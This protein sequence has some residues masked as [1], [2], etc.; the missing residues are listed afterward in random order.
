MPTQGECDYC[1]NPVRYVRVR[2]INRAYWGSLVTRTPEEWTVYIK[3]AGIPPEFPIVSFCG[4][5]K[6]RAE[7]EFVS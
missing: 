7:R 6:R 3:R 4:V 5:H 2:P 1:K